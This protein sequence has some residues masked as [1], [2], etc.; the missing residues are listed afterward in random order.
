MAPLAVNE[1]DEPEQILT[2][3]GVPLAG[4]SVKLKGTT[5]GTSTDVNG[6]FKLSIPAVGGVLEISFVGYTTYQVA[7]KKNEIINP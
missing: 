1:V 2:E 3:A 4:A 7:V 6:S 5:I